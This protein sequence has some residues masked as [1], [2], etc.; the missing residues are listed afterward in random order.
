MG[1]H[2]HIV[3]NLADPHINLAVTHAD[4]MINTD[5]RI[6]T[7]AYLGRLTRSIQPGKGIAINCSYL[8]QQRALVAVY[9]C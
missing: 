5:I 2:R 1:R 9:P 8:R 6:E 4:R 3:T 7:H